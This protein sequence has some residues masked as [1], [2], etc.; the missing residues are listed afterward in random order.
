[1]GKIDEVSNIFKKRM[2]EKTLEDLVEMLCNRP[3]LFYKPDK[4][5]YYD[6]M[7]Q[8]SVKQLREMKSALKHGNKTEEGVV[9]VG[10]S[11]YEEKKTVDLTEMDIGSDEDNSDGIN[12]WHEDSYPEPKKSA[13]KDE[14]TYRN[15]PSMIKR[16]AVCILKDILEYADEMTPEK[17]IQAVRNYTERYVHAQDTKYGY[18]RRMA[19]LLWARFYNFSTHEV[20]Y[21][22]AEGK[23]P[24]KE[25]KTFTIPDNMCIFEAQM[26][27]ECFGIEKNP[28]FG[29]IINAVAETQNVQDGEQCWKRSTGLMSTFMRRGV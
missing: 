3:Y 12:T 9:S 13:C 6:A 14:K 18:Q 7:N 28:R 22:M 2:T 24:K 21:C 20:A 19:F 25:C 8:F 4:N 1:M 16:F 26:F 23:D 15:D 29:R 17:M 11:R 5:K 10:V 27:Q